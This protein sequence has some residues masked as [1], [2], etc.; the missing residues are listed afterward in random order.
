[1]PLGAGAVPREDLR[2]RVADTAGVHGQPGLGGHTDVRREGYSS[3]GSPPAFRG[4][5]AR[6]ADRR[7]K[8][9]MAATA[10][11]RAPR[12][13]EVEECEA[14]TKDLA[15]RGRKLLRKQGE[16]VPHARRATQEDNHAACRAYLDHCCDVMRQQEERKTSPAKEP[17]EPKEA[18]DPKEAKKPS[19][20]KV[21][22]A[23]PTQPLTSAA[24][25]RRAPSR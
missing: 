21:A 6:L 1:M 5:A 4:A 23:P 8:R 11:V 18:K 25:G 19:G 10:A 2:A 13:K 24:K 17:K 12:K 14:L 22:A 7:Q 20:A 3:E 15:E 9:A 16:E